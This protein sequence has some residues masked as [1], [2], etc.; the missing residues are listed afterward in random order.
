MHDAHLTLP[1]VSHPASTLVLAETTR[2]AVVGKTTITASVAA[3]AKINVYWLF[4]L[5]RFRRQ[6]VNNVAQARLHG[7]DAAVPKAKL[8]NHATILRAAGAQRTT[9]NVTQMYAKDAMPGV[10]VLRICSA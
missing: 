3:S 1:S 10:I 2:N 5:R 9:V 8:T 6:T 4:A 7:K